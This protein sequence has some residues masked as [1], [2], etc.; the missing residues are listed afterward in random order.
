MSF[1]SCVCALPISGPLQTC[2]AHCVC[3]GGKLGGVMELGLMVFRR[4][5]CVCGGIVDYF[6]SS[7][8][9]FSQLRSEWGD[10]STVVVL[11]LKKY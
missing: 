4:H 11:L 5:K 10:P 2:V 6:C 9:V 8:F 7:L 3:S 1:C